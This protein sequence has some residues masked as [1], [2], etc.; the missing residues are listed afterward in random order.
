MTKTRV[1]ETNEG[2]QGLATVENYDI[3]QRNMRD[4]KMIETKDLIGAGIV[5]GTVLEVGPGPG[6]LGL[7]WLKATSATRLTAIDISNNMLKKARDNARSY[8]LSGRTEYI[9]GNAMEMPFADCSFDAVF[10]NGSLHEWEDPI[11]V[12]NEVYRVLKPGGRFLISDLKRD[13]SLVIRG[14]M[15]MTTKPVK[16]RPGLISS[17]N[18]A[19]TKDELIA[20]KNQSKLA[21]GEVAVNPFGIKLFG[22]KES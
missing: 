1:I 16:M 10:T 7:E 8:E 5:K 21:C 18:A 19:Y 2:I 6:Y 14:V 15:Y 3:L 17:I 13:V 11:L 22:Q 4:R 9:H 12:M 20:I